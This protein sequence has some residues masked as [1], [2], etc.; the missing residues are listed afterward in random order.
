M[1]KTVIPASCDR[2]SESADD[3]EDDGPSGRPS[4]NHVMMMGGSPD[5]TEQRTSHRCPSCKDEGKT[6]PSIAGRTETETKTLPSA[7]D[8][9]SPN[10]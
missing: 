8:P 7:F 6:K 3:E 2:D 5:V 1:L 10:A 4:L 9:E